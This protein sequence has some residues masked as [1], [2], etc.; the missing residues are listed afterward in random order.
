MP[1]RESTTK[2]S[3]IEATAGLDTLKGTFF[4]D[5]FQFKFTDDNNPKNDTLNDNDRIH[6]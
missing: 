1:G 3:V 5:T 4:P 6:R 2:K